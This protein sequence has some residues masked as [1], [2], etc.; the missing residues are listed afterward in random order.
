M[1]K[2]TDKVIEK[3]FDELEEIYIN[4]MNTQEKVAFEIAK[5]SLESS[6]DMIK[7]IGFKEFLAENNYIVKSPPK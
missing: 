6:Y 7:T 3:T 4:Q 1:N 2:N 5:S